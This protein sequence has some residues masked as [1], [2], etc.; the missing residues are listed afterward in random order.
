[1][2]ALL[3]LGCVALGLLLVAAS[4]QDLEESEKEAA[5]ERV[6]DDFVKNRDIRST[7]GKKSKPPRKTGAWSTLARPSKPREKRGTKES[8]NRQGKPKR[9][10]G[11]FTALIKREEL[12]KF[13]PTVRHNRDT[14]EHVKIKKYLKSKNKEKRRRNKGHKHAHYPVMHA[15]YPTEDP[16]IGHN[17]RR[18]HHRGKKERDRVRNGAFT[19]LGGISPNMEKMRPD[20]GNPQDMTE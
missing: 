1:M 18:K 8:S 19:G 9:C 11:C 5:N 6:Q 7:G 12:N 15:H 3:V 14:E 4:H 20:N 16:E 10:N 2:R 17:K 13:N